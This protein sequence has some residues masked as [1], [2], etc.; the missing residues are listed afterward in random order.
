MV[1]ETHKTILITGGAKRI[2]RALSEALAE[3]GWNIAIHYFGSSESAEILAHTLQQHGCQVATLYAD[4]SDEDET[5]KLV[6]SATDA[7][8]PLGALVNNASIFEEEQWDE[9]TSYSWARHLNVNLHAPFI[10]S[11]DFARALPCESHGI[12]TNIIDQR[13]FNLTPNFF[14]YTISKSG[15]WAM[16]QT[17]ALALAP[18]IRVNGVG[19]G[20]TLANEHQTEETFMAQA[21]A[22]PL[23]RKVDVEDIA[24]AVK[25][26]LGA[27]AVT[28][29]MIAVDSGEHLGWAQPVEGRHKDG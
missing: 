21:R 2:G 14:S 26:L 22:T 24:N 13:V 25:Y 8:G 6:A 15:L 10:L 23:Q 27:S 9:V 12:I 1:Q 28:G 16:T 3:D 19:P 20:P 18:R 5:R 7:L 4:L 17:L 11:Q 29:Q